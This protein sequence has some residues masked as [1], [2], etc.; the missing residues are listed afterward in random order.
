MYV[1]IYAEVLCYHNSP[2]FVMKVCYEGMY[3]QQEVICIALHRSL[4]S[5]HHR[6]VII[7]KKFYLQDKSSLPAWH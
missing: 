2:R 1:D 3:N 6:Y 5:K 7:K 4:T